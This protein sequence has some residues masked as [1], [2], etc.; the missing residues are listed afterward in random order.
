VRPTDAAPTPSVS[1]VGITGQLPGG[2]A[3]LLVA[4]DIEVPKNS[5]TEGMRERLAELVKEFDTLIV[6]GGEIIYLGTPQ[7]E[8]SIY[9]AVH[10]RGYYCRIW[11]AR[12]PDPGKLSK[13]DGALS[14]DI[15]ADIAAG[16]R[17]GSSTDPERFADL[18]LA[19][20]EGSYG[21]S[22]FA[23][24]F[25]LD[26]SLSDAE[27]YPL[28]TSDLIYFDCAQDDAPVRVVWTS[29]PRSAVADIPNVGFA[30]DRL[31]RPMHIADAR[32]KYTGAVMVIDPAGRGKD[33]TAVAVV[34]ALMGEL[35]LTALK[36]MQGGYEADALQAIAD[37]AKAQKV[38]HI[39]IESN[40]GDGMF[41]KMLEPYMVKTHPCT[42]KE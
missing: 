4:D 23:L 7:T 19:E 35:F 28:K 9:N 29:D 31:Y 20:R 33:Q 18:D 34:K 2:R 8:Q 16:A 24:Q 14:E 27:R 15:L 41:Q 26:T 10:K 5:F 17:A 6:P 13:Y 22:G 36:G 12:F 39:L 3:T 30:G 42:I 25:M 32:D 38:K 1:A 40:F 37:L 11:P 21:R